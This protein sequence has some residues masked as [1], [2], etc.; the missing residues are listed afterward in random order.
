MPSG[1]TAQ[2][3]LA[4]LVSNPQWPP[5][6]QTLCSLFFL[7]LKMIDG[8]I[9]FWV[10]VSLERNQDIFY[11]SLAFIDLVYLG[12]LL[13]A[14]FLSLLSPSVTPVP[15]SGSPNGRMDNP[16]TDLCSSEHCLMCLA[17]SFLHCWDLN[18]GLC[19]CWALW[20]Q[21]PKRQHHLWQGMP[22]S[23]RPPEA[24]LRNQ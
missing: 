22:G 7:S 6:S 9:C 23:T 13:P 1:C 18:T 4:C 16:Y 24:N 2:V 11:S 21:F 20:E 17:S 12:W 3:P 10:L 5:P 8:D 14:L 15:S 19:G